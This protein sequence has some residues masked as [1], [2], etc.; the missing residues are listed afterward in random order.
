MRPFFLSDAV[1]GYAASL[2]KIQHPENTHVLVHTC[3]GHGM[4]HGNVS[5]KC[6]PCVQSCLWRPGA[7]LEVAVKAGVIAFQWAGVKLQ[8]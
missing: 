8:L 1:L 6:Y 7:V 5:Y 3:M 2:C 4:A